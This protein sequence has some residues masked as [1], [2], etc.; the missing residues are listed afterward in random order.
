MTTLLRFKSLSS[1]SIAML[2]GFGLSACIA[3]GANSASGGAT[4]LTAST[5][6]G[7]TATTTTTTETAAVETPAAVEAP[8]ATVA[9]TGSAAYD[10]ASP[11]PSGS[12]LLWKPHSEID[13]GLVILVPAAMGGATPIIKRA[14]GEVFATA[15]E[16]VEA[17][18]HNL[19]NGI[20]YHYVFGRGTGS[21]FPMPSILSIGG[22]NYQIPNPAGRYE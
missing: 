13:G 22:A 11:F 18:G 21:A 3:D 12:C 1:L 4:G 9:A 19:C 7:S 8:V 20:R 5:S 10:A 2:I 6:T 17:R 14:N 15:R 16:H